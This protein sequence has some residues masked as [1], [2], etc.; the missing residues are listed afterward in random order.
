MTTSTSNDATARRSSLM[1]R[2]DFGVLDLGRFPSFQTH[3]REVVH[4]IVMSEMAPLYHGRRRTADLRSGAV[5]TVSVAVNPWV[6]IFETSNLV[7]GGAS[8]FVIGGLAK[9]E[10]VLKVIAHAATL[11]S[12][13]EAKRAKLAAEKAEHELTAFR[14]RLAKVAS[15]TS[16]EHRAE[17]AAVTLRGVEG[18]TAPGNSSTANLR[19][20]MISASSANQLRIE[21][22]DLTEHA[23]SLAEAERH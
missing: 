5:T 15:D 9:A 13:I 1:I 3:V 11:K 19:A 22:S 23:S 21:A 10:A 14:A 16:D 20:Q 4:G 12:E 7:I 2:V 8:A 18:L 17:M 6:E